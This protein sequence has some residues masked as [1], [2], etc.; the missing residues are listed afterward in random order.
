VRDDD[1][2]HVVR[3]EPE[4]VEAMDVTWVERQD[5]IY[6]ITG[7]TSEERFRAHAAAF[8][9]A[10]RSLRRLTTAERD[11][12]LVLRLRLVPAEPGEAL[13]ALARRTGT[14][15]KPSEIAL[16]NGLGPESA[17]G[18]A[19]LVKVALPEPWRPAPSPPQAEPR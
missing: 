16:A 17:L 1:E 3:L 6:R 10:A 9:A 5:G 4:G 2:V 7:R 14:P 8:L 15:W 12:V 11:G 13:A 18:E 19:R